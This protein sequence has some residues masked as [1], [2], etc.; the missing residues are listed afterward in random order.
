MLLL[1]LRAITS[2]LK[3]HRSLTLENLALRHQLDVLQ[4]NRRPLHL[5][6]RDRTLWVVD[7]LRTIGIE[8]IITARKSPWQSGYV[9]R[10]IGSVRR[11][12]LDHMIVLNQR[13][14]RRI[15]KEYFEY[16]H[17]ARTHLGLGKDSPV[18]RKIEPP[19]CGPVVT[20]PMVGGLHH[21]YHRKAA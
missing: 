18:P 14:L 2:S 4:R 8:Q 15:L 6:N 5:T 17:E 20:E 9:E 10:V 21:R 11:E 7:T 19:E 16:Y 13:H 3:S 1:I 12:C